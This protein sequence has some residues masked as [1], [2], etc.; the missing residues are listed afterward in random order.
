[1]M[2]LCSGMRRA[3]GVVRCRDSSSSKRKGSS[4]IAGAAVALLGYNTHEWIKREWKR[5][6]REKVQRAA[7]RISE[8][9][10]QWP[11]KPEKTEQRVVGRTTRSPRPDEEAKC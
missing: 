8:Q 1:M 6:G 9:W 4:E 7:V 3:K 11:R 2:Y 10:E 5:R